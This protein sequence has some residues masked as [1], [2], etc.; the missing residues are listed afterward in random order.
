VLTGAA[1]TAVDG[2]DV[3]ARL[4]DGSD[5]SLRAGVV[6]NAAGVWAQRLAPSIRLMPSRGSHL[7]VPG[8]VLGSRP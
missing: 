1:V 8:P 2:A 5:L 4:D 7:V 6:V 3:H